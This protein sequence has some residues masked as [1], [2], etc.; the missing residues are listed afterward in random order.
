MYNMSKNGSSS[1]KIIIAS[2]APVMHLDLLGVDYCVH[3]VGNVWRSVAMLKYIQR[4]VAILY[5]QK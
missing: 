1:A 3:S 2:E 4:L 5:Q